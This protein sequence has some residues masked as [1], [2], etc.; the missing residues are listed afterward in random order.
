VAGGDGNNAVAYSYDGITWAAST[1]GNALFTG[2][3]ALA[4]SYVQE[5]AVNILSTTTGAVRNLAWNGGGVNTDAY[6]IQVRDATLAIGA[7]QGSTAFYQGGMREMLIYTGTLSDTNKAQITDY[8]YNKWNP[9]ALTL[10]PATPIK[11]GLVQWLDA[12]DLTTLF[13]DLSGTIPASD[14]EIV[15]LWKDKSGNGYDMYNDSSSTAATVTVTTINYTLP[16]YSKPVPASKDITLFVVLK[17]NN[18]SNQLGYPT[19]YSLWQHNNLGLNGHGQ[20]GTISFSQG[21]DK[22]SSGMS[23]SSA[24]FTI[25]SVTL[26]KAQLVNLQQITISGISTLRDTVEVDS[27]YTG[28]GGPVVLCANKAYGGYIYVGEVIYYNRVLSTTEISSTISYLQNKWGVAAAAAGPNLT[29][30]L[31]LWLDAADPYTVFQNA[32]VMTIWKDRSANGYNAT[33]SGSPTYSDGGVVFNGTSQFFNLPNGALPSGN[34]PYSYYAVIKPTDVSGVGIIGG[35]ADTA[36]FGQFAL[37]YTNL[38]MAMVAGGYGTNQL[39]YSSDG[40]TWTASASGNSIFSARCSAVAWNGVLWVAGGQGGNQLAYSSDGI[41]W[42][43]STSGNAVLTNICF[44]VAWNG[45]RWVAGGNGTNRLAY[46]SDGINWTAS[47]SGNAVLT[48]LCYAVA[49]NGTRWVAGGFGTNRIAYSSDGITWT[50]ST[51]GNEVFTNWCDAVAWGGSKWVAGG[52]GV[53]A[54]LAY[55]SDGITWTASTSGNTVLQICYAVAWNGTRWVAGG[56]GVGSVTLAYSSDGITWT[57]SI[58][59]GNVLTGQCTAVAW[60]GTRWVAGAEAAVGATRNQL[61]YSS[62][63]ITW[64]ASESGNNA[65]TTRCEALASTRILPSTTTQYTPP[66]VLQTTIGPASLPATAFVAGGGGTNRLVYSADGINWAVSASGNAVFSTHCFAVAWNGTLWVAGGSGTYG[67][68]NSSLA[69]SSDGIKWTASASGNSLFTSCSAVGWNGTLWV[70]GG[71]GSNR[72][73]Y[74]SDGIEWTASTS[75][76]GIF[77]N[78]C[79]AVAWN[80]TRWVAGGSANNRLAYS[81]DGITWTASTSGNGIFSN[82]CNAV[83]WNGT[84][85][86]AAGS[87]NNRLAYSS[88]GITWTAS[89]S[90]NALITNF[91]TGVAW[92]GTIWVVTGAGTNSLIYSSDGITWTASTSG[93]E[94]F[95][96]GCYAPAWNGTR[97]V[98]VASEKIGYSSDGITGYPVQHLP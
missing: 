5:A 88:D 20:T 61:A 93:N 24:T 86:V 23:Q 90:G 36:T 45:T 31:Q 87:E 85:W 56:A 2:G 98:V 94:I 12:N 42:T 7:V 84:R 29:D 21:Y 47:T 15:R 75:G 71:G 63:G 19:G 16:G 67:Q 83:A 26:S 9:P 58:S 48:S 60:N 82:G 41:T 68:P 35:G 91:S 51:S 44:A 69:Y 17:N 64:I 11:H 33:P 8:L 70:A 38:N 10:V 49:W 32:G 46:S 89:T 4:S 57:V 37:E 3:L 39:A 55:S 40:I 50:A 18:G 62:D 34:S 54:A 6:A 77:S 66:A 28:L 65:F 95:P 52:S 76:N 43:A 22:F 27:Y 79:N 59:G 30:N 25:Y 13:Q 74:S 92:N 96:G 78:A 97:W 73:A 14:T 72:L 53:S 81:S 80:G 1:S